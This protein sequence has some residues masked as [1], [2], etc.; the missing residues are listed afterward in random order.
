VGTNHISG[1][2]KARVIK[3]CTPVGY[4]RSKHTEDESPLKGAW[5]GS[6]DPFFNFDTGTTKATVAKFT[7]AGKI[8]QVLGFRW[9]TTP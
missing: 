5:S 4:L 3:F 2:A 6:S 9:Q 1:T 8:Y 7:I